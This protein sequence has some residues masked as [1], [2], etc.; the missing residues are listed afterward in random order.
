MITMGFAKWERDGE[1]CGDNSNRRVS[2]R[3]PGIKA[4]KGEIVVL[5]RYSD[6]S[7]LVTDVG[8]GVLGTKVG[9][10]MRLFTKL[11]FFKHETLPDL[12]G[13]QIRSE[14]LRN[15]RRAKYMSDYRRANTPVKTPDKHLKN[16]YE[17]A[18]NSLNKALEELEKE[19]NL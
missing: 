3:R 4:L 8:V 1:Y 19:L 15:C 2:Y 5:E 14:D 10:K 12:G 6:N 11:H 7:S 9:D 17:Q 13:P 16:Y 18:R